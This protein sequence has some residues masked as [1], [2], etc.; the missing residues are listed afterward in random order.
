MFNRDNLPGIL[1]VGLC[2]I[3]A[4]ILLRE[5]FTDYVFTLSGNAILIIF[6]VGSTIMV[7]I[8]RESQGSGQNPDGPTW[9]ANDIRTET[10]AEKRSKR[11]EQE[12]LHGNPPITGNIE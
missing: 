12:T 8:H 9:P 1:L 5:I 7:F 4:A 6:A 11:I 2:G 10:P 3:L